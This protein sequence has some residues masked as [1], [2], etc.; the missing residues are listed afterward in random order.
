MTKATRPA[1]V[2]AA[3]RP[4]FCCIAT[5]RRTLRGGPG[6]VLRGKESK[7]TALWPLV[8]DVASV[9]SGVKILVLD[10]GFIN[11]EKI[12]HLKQK[13][14]IDTVIPIRSDM[15]IIEDVQGAT[16]LPTSWDEYEAKAPPVAAEFAS[17]A[18]APSHGHQA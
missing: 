7:A 2:G 13:H 11:G 10:R 9:G 12:G 17:V 18:S 15:D 14:G 16:Q 4:C 6:C 3:T 5:R 8:E 1:A